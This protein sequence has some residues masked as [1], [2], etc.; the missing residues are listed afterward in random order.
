MPAQPLDVVDEVRRRVVGEL[1]RRRRASRAALVEEH[2]PPER[3]IEKAAMMRQAAAAGSAV[4]EQERHAVGVAARLPVQRVQRIDREHSRRVRRRSRDK[5]VAGSGS[6]LGVGIVHR[7]ATV[8]DAVSSHF[9]TAS[10]RTRL[11]PA[12]CLP[13]DARRRMLDRQRSGCPTLA[14]PVLVR[15]DGDDLI[16]LSAIAPTASRALRARRSRRPRFARARCRGSASLAAALANA[17]AEDRNLRR[18]GCSRRATCRRSRQRRH[19]RRE[20]AGARDR[21]AGARRSGEGRRRAAHDRRGMHRRQ[22]R[23]ASSRARRRPRA[24]RRC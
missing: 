17:S 13:A 22:P 3:R 19:L 20:H 9:M 1:R 23:A 10:L 18:R 12:A 14:G 4:Q 8:R 6:W 24:S 5:S 21:G 11:T 15:V 16:D 2:D 7:A